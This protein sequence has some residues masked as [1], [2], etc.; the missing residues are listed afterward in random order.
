MKR[1]D[2]ERRK[3]EKVG[4]SGQTLE[5]AME[6]LERSCSISSAPRAASTCWRVSPAVVSASMA[7]ANHREMGE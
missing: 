6:L 5:R 3:L 2:K 4:F 1:L 7:R